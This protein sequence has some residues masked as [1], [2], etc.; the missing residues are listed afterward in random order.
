MRIVNETGNPMDTRILN[1][2]GEDVALDIEV[3]RIV[4]EVG[5]PVKVTMVGFASKLDVKSKLG[6]NVTYIEKG[7]ID[8]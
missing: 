2:K 6:D 5:E 4:I 8:G 3:S 7:L 1:D